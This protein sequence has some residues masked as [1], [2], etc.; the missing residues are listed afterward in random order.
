MFSIPL[1]TQLYHISICS[2]RPWHIYLF[3]FGCLAFNSWMHEGTIFLHYINPNIWS[4]SPYFPVADEDL[5]MLVIYSSSSPLHPHFCISLLKGKGKIYTC[6]YNR[7]FCYL[8]CLPVLSCKKQSSISYSWVYPVGGYTSNY[9]IP[10]Q[11]LLFCVLNPQFWRKVNIERTKSG[12]FPTQLLLVDSSV[13][14]FLLFDFPIFSHV[15]T[16][17]LAFFIHP[18]RISNKRLAGESPSY[19]SNNKILHEVRISIDMS[20]QWRS[21]NPICWCPN[22]SRHISGDGRCQSRAE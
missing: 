6:V 13:M 9:Y 4:R 21:R 2:I 8:L 11:W 16:Q 12:L 18:G 17:G 22:L 15:T 1:R 3:H 14:A 5:P 10:I 7:M 20:E 19:S